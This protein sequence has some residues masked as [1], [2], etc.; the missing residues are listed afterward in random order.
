MAQYIAG[1]DHFAQNVVPALDRFWAA[2]IRRWQKEAAASFLAGNDI[3]TSVQHPKQVLDWPYLRKPVVNYHRDACDYRTWAGAADNAAPPV[4][5]QGRIPATQAGNPVFDEHDNPAGVV[6]S[7]ITCP[8]PQVMTAVHAWAKAERDLI[9]A[10][11]PRFDGHDLGA[12]DRAFNGL[13]SIRE[14]TAVAGSS[15]EG[16]RNASGSALSSLVTDLSDGDGTSQ[17]WLADWTGLAADAFKGGF[18]KS[19]NPTTTNHY[20]LANELGKLVQQRSGI[21]QVGRN[22]AVH[23]ISEAAKGLGATGTAAI[24]NNWEALEGLAKAVGFL[25]VVG[26][27]VSKVLDLGAF[28]GEQFLATHDAVVFKGEFRAIV[29]NLS[30]GMDALVQQIETYEGKY[31]A[32]TAALRSALGAVGS[33]DIE[34]YALGENKAQ[35]LPT[36]QHSGFSADPAALFELA[37]KLGRA[38]AEYEEM[39]PLLDPVEDAAAHFADKDGRATGADTD[40]LAMAA[41]FRGFLTTTAARYFIARDQV[42]Q[43]AEDYKKSDGDVAASF[44]KA[45]AR[46]DKSEGGSHK[47][48]F[49]AKTEADATGRGTG[50]DRN[51][52][53]DHEGDLAYSTTKNPG[54]SVANPTREP[55]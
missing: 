1:P 38:G 47:P 17:H 43:G 52:Y 29:T 27:A 13:K 35:G 54:G 20:I 24:A 21:V 23:L 46:F 9:E 15:T 33:F 44:T 4:R 51:P 28:L 26:D 6:P 31:R 53:R 12:L 7:E 48:G 14:Q 32:L 30:A 45:L 42:R 16:T 36:A 37:E 49:D 10:K 18:L 25:P 55:V 2:L 19:T 34:L 39:L 40:A 8:L 50:A 3:S 11:V 5:C 41:E 22:D